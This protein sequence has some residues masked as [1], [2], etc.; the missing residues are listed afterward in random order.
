MSKARNRILRVAK[1]YLEDGGTLAIQIQDIC[2][3]AEV[4]RTTFYREFQNANEVVATL[5]INRWRH[6]LQRMVVKY[7]LMEPS[8]EQWK[9]FLLEFSQQ[10]Q[11]ESSYLERGD[12]MIKVIEVL[13]RKDSHYLQQLTEILEPCIQQAQREGL[14]RGY[15]EPV[16]I[17]DWLM[18]QI[19]GVSS[20]PFPG[21]KEEQ[22]L[23]TYLKDFVYPTLFTTSSKQG[24][25][26]EIISK[27]DRLAQTLDRIERRI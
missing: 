7:R 8:V 19:W 14:I 15:L 17:V 4:S 25:S 23:S 22:S 16:F 26:E 18:R 27:I 11:G 10:S 1:N 5:A 3:Q 20:V 2:K 24:E 13:Y 12:G 9:L 6:S 21:P